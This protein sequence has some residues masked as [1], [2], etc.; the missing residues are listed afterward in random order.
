MR[1][2]IE[3]HPFTQY[4]ELMTTGQM[5]VVTSYSESEDGSCDTCIVFVDPKANDDRL[6]LASGYEVFGVSY[7]DLRPTRI[8]VPE[9]ILESLAEPD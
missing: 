3:S 1:A 2:R 7:E 6:E 9:F 8:P 5:V 4:Y